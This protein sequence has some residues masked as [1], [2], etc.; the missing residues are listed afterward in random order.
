MARAWET[1]FMGYANND[2]RI[3]SL[4]VM[5]EVELASSLKAILVRECHSARA[6]IFID[7]LENCIAISEVTE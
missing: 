7:R 2:P 6:V 5:R 3:V 4:V 1:G